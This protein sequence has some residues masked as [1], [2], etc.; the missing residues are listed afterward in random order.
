M[1]AVLLAGGAGYIGSHAA[2]ALRAARRDVVVLD[3]LEAG[4]RGAVHGIPLVVADIADKRVVRDTMRRYRVTSVMHFAALLS[5]GESVRSPARYYAGNVAKTLALLDAMVEEGVKRLVFSSTAAV[6]G[7][8]RETPITENHSTRPV[9]PYGETKLAIENLLPH[10]E[11]AYG[12]RAVR[13][14]YFNAAGA[15]PEGDIGE[16]HRPEEHLIPCALAAAAGGPPLTV[17]G[18]D[19]PTPD[20]TCLR[21]YV[22]VS[23]LAA[24]HMLALA[25][26]ESGAPLRVCNL[27]S[28]RGYSVREVVAAVERV[29]GATVPCEAAGRRGGD[30][31]VLLASGARARS[32][33][34]WE[35][36]YVALDA[37]VETAWRWHRS[38][39]RG[40]ES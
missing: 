1:G 19:Y 10:Y 4:H 21:D 40:Y 37:I 13:L 23:D 30:P 14:R 3:N 33:L 24:A 5:V 34:G 6:Y 35:P 18:D 11:R 32:E 31:A 7:E 39:P 22:H 17:F 28:G 8:P 27:G 29:T 12:L 38:H 16:D 2:R 36:V 25:A 20:G 9:N 15:D 26:L